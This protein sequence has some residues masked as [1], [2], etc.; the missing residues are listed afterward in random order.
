MPGKARLFNIDEYAAVLKILEDPVVINIYLHSLTPQQI[1]DLKCMKQKMKRSMAVKIG[2]FRY[3]KILRS[4]DG[5]RTVDLRK[6]GG[7]YRY[8]K[9]VYGE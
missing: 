9:K 4:K 5:L 8:R 3:L 6:H 7:D 1:D 2:Y